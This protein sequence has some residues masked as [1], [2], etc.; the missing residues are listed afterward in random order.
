METQEKNM[1]TTTNPDELNMGGNGM[2]QQDYTPSEPLTSGTGG[3]RSLATDGPLA[4]TIDDDDDDLTDIGTPLEDD[5][6]D[7]L[8]GGDIPDLDTEFDDD[9]DLLADDDDDLTD[10]DDDDLDT[11]DG[12]LKDINNPT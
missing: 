8:V 1:Q 12:P 10:V 5:D 9:D 11:L 2:P 4:Q 6:D 7:E 3:N